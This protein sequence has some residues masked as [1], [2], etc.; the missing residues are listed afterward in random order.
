MCL[1]GLLW[2][3]W[4]ILFTVSWQRIFFS[5]LSSQLVYEFF[6]RFLE[7]P[8]FQ[9]SIGMNAFFVTIADPYSF[10]GKKVIDQKFVL[11][12]LELFDSEDPRWTTTFLAF[13]IK[14]LFSENETS[15]RRF[16]IESMANFWV[17][18]P[19]SENRS[20]T[21]SSGLLYQLLVGASL[22]SHLSEAQ[23]SFAP[24]I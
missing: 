12:L 16:C 15:W 19:S 10:A 14:L 1:L 9:P 6:L 23:I 13:G 11:Q 17:S 24:L 20:T 5:L 3:T 18:V 7:S 22:Y 4:D 2:I 21:F 8:D